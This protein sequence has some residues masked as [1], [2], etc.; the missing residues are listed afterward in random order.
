M[1]FLT[2]TAKGR[3]G[4]SGGA[5]GESGF[6]LGLGAPLHSAKGIVSWLVR[7]QFSLK[8]QVPKGCFPPLRSGKAV[9]CEAVQLGQLC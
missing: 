6:E 9:A 3:E 8:F 5:S 7:T 1:W 4:G 2:S